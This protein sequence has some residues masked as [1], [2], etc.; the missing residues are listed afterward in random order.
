M[1]HETHKYYQQ[2]LLS[3]TP[4]QIKL[5]I[6]NIFGTIKHECGKIKFYTPNNIITTKMPNVEVKSTAQLHTRSHFTLMLGYN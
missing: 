4:G 6:D 5:Y 3:T 2:N 1:L